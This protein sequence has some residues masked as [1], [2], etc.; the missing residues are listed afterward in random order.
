M[1]SLWIHF[2]VWGLLKPAG[3]LAGVVHL[4]KCTSQVIGSPIKATTKCHLKRWEFSV[5]G[6]LELLWEHKWKIF[7]EFG[8]VK[9]ISYPMNSKL[10]LFC[11]KRAEKHEFKDT[12]PSQKEKKQKF[13]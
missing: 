8:K 3:G 12:F 13:E 5:L 1:T 9:G 7:R 10:S 6:Y 2:E 4:I 11:P